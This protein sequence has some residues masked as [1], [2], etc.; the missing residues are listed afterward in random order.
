MHS[1]R[2]VENNEGYDIDMEGIFNNLAQFITAFVRQI[3]AISPFLAAGGA[4]IFGMMYAFGGQQA[5]QFAKQRGTQMV[6]GL[7][8]IWLVA[9][10]VNTLIRLAGVGGN[11]NNITLTI[12]PFTQYLGLW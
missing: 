9:T 6:V 2:R 7:I 5:A 10:V 11:I 4:V 1:E 3:Q 8:V 12:M